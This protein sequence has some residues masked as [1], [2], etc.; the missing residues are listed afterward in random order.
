M[1]LL[2]EN[3]RKFVNEVEGEQL[4]LPG[5]ED[6]IEPNDPEGISEKYNI[7]PGIAKKLLKMKEEGLG[8]ALYLEGDTRSPPS[9][10]AYFYELDQFGPDSPDPD[11]M[12]RESSQNGVH[13]S[14]ASY[15]CD[16]DPEVWEINLT[17]ARLYPGMGPVLY[18]AALE[19][20]SDYAHGLVSDRSTVSEYAREVWEYYE[21]RPDVETIQLDIDYSGTELP[22]DMEE[23]DADEAI[24]RC[25]DEYEDYTDWTLEVED[26]V[27]KED[28]I[29]EDGD[30]DEYQWD[31]DVQEKAAELSD[32][33]KEEHCND[34]DG[35]SEYLVGMDITDIPQVTPDDE[36]DDCI[37]T[38]A[39][40][41][42]ADGGSIDD[43]DE[44]AVSKAYFKP[45]VPMLKWLKKNNML[46][47]TKED[48]KL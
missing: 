12:P 7:Y 14:A 43:W 40:Q 39:L 9:G 28:Y 8:L 34:Y 24:E 35:Y 48:F 38:S 30:F 47:F 5:M 26:Y 11:L 31:Q 33:W 19:V 25:M 42:S 4:P 32:N 36:S 1:K 10:V 41:H 16:V 15:N 45:M 37:Q 2:F 20:A 22:D 29:D 13:F 17:N 18:E 23:G 6:E 46:L 3:W 27:D 21:K 44:M